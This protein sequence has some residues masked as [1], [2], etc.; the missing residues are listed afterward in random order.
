[1]LCGNVASCKNRAHVDE[2][3]K[4]TK[5]IS[6]P[7]RYLLVLTQYTRTHLWYHNVEETEP[8]HCDASCRCRSK[9]YGKC[10]NDSNNPSGAPQRRS[11]VR[12]L[13]HFKNCPIGKSTFHSAL[14][15]FQTPKK[16]NSQK[17]RTHRPNI[18]HRDV[19]S[20]EVSVSPSPSSCS[21]HKVPTPRRLI[22]SHVSSSCPRPALA[23][24]LRDQITAQSPPS[25]PESLFSSYPGARSDINV[26]PRRR[27]PPYRYLRS[28]P[29]GC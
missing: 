29:A 9:A 17:S 21:P 23:Q 4:L 12:S 8:P 11:F 3:I 16:E 15:K 10:R 1:M 27:L 5:G 26:R 2:C 24:S 28:K 20:L 14:S 13:L 25:Q 6:D 7:G 18:Q 22:R 19:S